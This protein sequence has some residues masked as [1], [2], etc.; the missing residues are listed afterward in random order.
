MTTPAEGDVVTGT[1]A[2]WLS[3]ATDVAKLLAIEARLRA[4]PVELVM[5]KKA[6]PLCGAAPPI[7]VVAV[8][9]K[10]DSVSVE[11]FPFPPVP[12]V[13]AVTV[14]VAPVEVAVAPAVPLLPAIAAA[15][16]AASLVVTLLALVTPMTKFV[17][18][19]EPVPRAPVAT[20]VLPAF[21][22][23]V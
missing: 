9:V 13:V 2:S 16:L 6:S 4:V 10:F 7:S 1:P 15:R 19:F 23:K 18:V 11:A 8:Q 3:A 5:A 20:V 14:T 22:D 17:P 21:S 12:G